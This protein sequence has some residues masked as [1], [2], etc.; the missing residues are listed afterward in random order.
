ME[1]LHRRCARRRSLVLSRVVSRWGGTRPPA[2][3]HADATAPAD[4]QFGSKKPDLRQQRGSAGCPLATRRILPAEKRRCPLM[5]LTV[6][7]D[8]GAIGRPGRVGTGRR[9]TAVGIGVDDG[10]VLLRPLGALRGHAA[11]AGSARPVISARTT[12]SRTPAAH[13]LAAG[14]DEPDLTLVD[15]LGEC[16]HGR[17]WVLAAE[18]THPHDRGVAMDEV[19]LGGHR[20]ALHRQG[21]PGAT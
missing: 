6:V 19:G 13:I 14:Q 18:P 5:G 21:D 12:A 4:L 2:A 17:G 9:G 20:S 16:G 8:V 1:V 11:P 7:E 10:A 15:P 3:H